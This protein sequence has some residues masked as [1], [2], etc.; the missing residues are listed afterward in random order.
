MDGALEDEGPGAAAPFAR[1][2][3]GPTLIGPAQSFLK[4]HLCHILHSLNHGQ[5]VLINT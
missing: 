5:L 1:P 4:K 2:P 3:L